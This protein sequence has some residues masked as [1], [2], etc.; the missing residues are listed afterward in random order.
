VG[1]VGFGLVVGGFG[2][3]GFFFHG[4]VAKLCRIKDFSAVLALNEFDVVLAGDNFD[5]WM[6]AV[7]SHRDWGVMWILPLSKVVVN[8]V[9]M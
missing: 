9:L 5:D 2:G 1:F 8:D 6:F 7:G 3:S 4:H